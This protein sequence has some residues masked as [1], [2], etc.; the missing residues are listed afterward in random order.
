[1]LTVSQCFPRSHYFICIYLSIFFY[2]SYVH[3]TIS[4][5]SFR[6]PRPQ[7]NVRKI[8]MG[9]NC[10]PTEVPTEQDATERG[11]PERDVFDELI[12]EPPAS[13]TPPDERAEE[14][15]QTSQPPQTT[16]VTRGVGG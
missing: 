5:C 1:M 2:F 3:D 15:P 16:A 14:T 9:M 12:G 6:L 11:D 4:S 8:R 10:L 7:V 13:P